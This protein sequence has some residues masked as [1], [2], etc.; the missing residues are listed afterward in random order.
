[1]CHSRNP[2]N[3]LKPPVKSQNRQDPTQR[4]GLPSWS[5]SVRLVRWRLKEKKLLYK[6]YHKSREGKSSYGILKSHNRDESLEGFSFYNFSNLL[7]L[8]LTITICL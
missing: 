4:L 5:W 1:M 8:L 3:D 6:K 7:C 2:N